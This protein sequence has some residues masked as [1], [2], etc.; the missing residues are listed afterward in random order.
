MA[1]LILINPHHRT[2]FP[3]MDR[4]LLLKIVAKSLTY[5]LLTWLTDVDY[6]RG[7]LTWADMLVTWFLVN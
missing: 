3:D 7:L 2:P 6:L 5:G 4:V 1:L